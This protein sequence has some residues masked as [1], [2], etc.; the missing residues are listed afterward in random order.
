MKKALI[1]STYNRPKALALCLE[2][3]KGQSMLP[4]E[5]IIADDGSTQETSILIEN[6]SK[7]FPVAIKHIWHEDTGFKLAQIR[8]KAIAATDADF[9][10]QIDGD[11]ILHKRYVEDFITQ[12]APGMVILGSRVGLGP[13]LTRK[14]E[15]RGKLMK[16]YPWTIG[17]NQKPARAIYLKAGR[18]ISRKYKFDQ[19]KGLGCSM[20]FWRKDFLEVNGY[21]ESFEGWGCE[22]RDLTRRLH[23]NGVHNHKLLFIGIVYHLWHKEADRSSHKINREICYNRNQDKIRI[24]KGISQYL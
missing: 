9:I 7:D 13:R 20:G 8:N 17:I 1:I 2:S 6:I 14:L 23:R 4:D 21:D 19:T 12:A 11:V 16:I 10:M 5:V 3:V 24:E 22:D 18:K 15:E